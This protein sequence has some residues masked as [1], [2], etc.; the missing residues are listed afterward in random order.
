MFKFFRKYQQTSFTI[1]HV[2][3]KYDVFLFIYYYF[4]LERKSKLKARV[5]NL[6]LQN[7]RVPKST[8]KLLYKIC[9]FCCLVIN[10]SYLSH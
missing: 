10:L 5:L 1:E 4:F 3:Q 9:L 6:E 2:E 8:V 7:E